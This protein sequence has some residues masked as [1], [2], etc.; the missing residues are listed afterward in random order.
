M[1]VANGRLDPDKDKFTSISTK[2]R[3]VVDTFAQIT[4][5]KKNI[6]N[7]EVIDMSDAVYLLGARGMTDIPAKISDKPNRYQKVITSGCEVITS[8]PEKCVKKANLCMHY[9][10]KV[11]QGKYIM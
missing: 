6:E 3:A 8:G 5:I 7:V 9:F 11:K 10:T 4:E 2:G 1:C